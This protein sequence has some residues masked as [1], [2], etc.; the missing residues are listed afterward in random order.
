MNVTIEPAT[1]TQHGTL[2]RN[3]NQL[4]I[5]EFARFDPHFELGPDGRFDDSDLDEAWADTEYARFYLI[6]VDGVVAG[7]AILILNIEDDELGF[8]HELA[9]FFVLAPYQ[10]QGIGE[11]AARQLFDLHPGHWELYVLETNL[12]ALAFWRKILSRYS[13]GIYNEQ[14]RPEEHDY[15]FAFSNLK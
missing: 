2:I 10:Q 1:Q 13:Q 7:Y 11:Q 3:L 9:E 6:R 12:H 15:R 14:P 4:Y 5:Y 8:V